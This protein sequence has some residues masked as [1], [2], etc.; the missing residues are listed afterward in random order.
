MIKQTS[1]QVQ[2]QPAHLPVRGCVLAYLQSSRGG[3]N[4]QSQRLTMHRLLVFADYCESTGVGVQEVNSR[5]V[6]DFIEHLVATHP[7]RKRGATQ[8][9]TVTIVGFVQCIKSMLLWASGDE[10]CY[11][12]YVSEK[13]IKRIARP[14]QDEVLIEVLTDAHIRA[15]LSACKAEENPR[16]VARAKIAIHLLYST[17]IRAS[18]L[19]NLRLEHLHLD[20][21]AAYLMIR[22]GKG[23]KD[24]RVPM[25][26]TCRRKL[27]DYILTWRANVP[28]TA[29]V[30]A[31]R[32]GTESLTVAGLQQLMRRL[33]RRAGIDAQIPVHPHVFRHTFSANF[34]R[35]GG[36]I[37][38]LQRILGHSSTKITEGYI[39]SLGSDFD[40]HDRAVKFMP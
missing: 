7:G 19:C 25:G 13:V 16:Q 5:I 33:S 10:L 32:D 36:D 1:S 20:P 40:L 34:L 24:R 26:E 17:G 18:E 30:F 4:P 2:P 35:C 28:T 9:S 3:R 38:T 6:N 23:R 12:E 21:M 8:M 14:K 31:S 27:E 39:K 37:Y 29:P 11:A 22:Q 15:L